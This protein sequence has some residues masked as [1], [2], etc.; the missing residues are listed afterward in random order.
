MYAI[1]KSFKFE[2]AH[3]LEGL[4]E[5]HQCG[6]IHGHS[7]SVSVDLASM[8]LTTEG[9]I[10]DFG[11]L[12]PFREYLAKEF[13]HRNLNEVCDFQTTSENLA[14]HFYNWVKINIAL[15]VNSFLQS[16]TVSETATSSASYYE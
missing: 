9:W 11:K 8:Q 4:P 6:R 1:S 7:Y 14:R 13:D 15:P 16:V 5:G 3:R 12:A 10:E 2:A